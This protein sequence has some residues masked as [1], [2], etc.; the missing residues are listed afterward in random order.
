MAREPRA[1][2]THADILLC[3]ALASAAVVVTL[4]N[5]PLYMQDVDVFM[6]ISRRLLAGQ[7]LYRD[8]WMAYPPGLFYLYAGLMKLFGMSHQVIKLSAVVLFAAVPPMMYLVTRRYASIAA[9]LFAA[10]LTVAVYPPSHKVVI[11]FFS[12]TTLWVISSLGRGATRARLVAA[13]VNVALAMLFKHE[14]GFLLS[15]AVLTCVWLAPAETSLAVRRK[16]ARIAWYVAGILLPVLPT[17][18]YFWFRRALKPF[19][20]DLIVEPFYSVSGMSISI[21]PPLSGG[22]SATIGAWQQEVV[23]H[24]VYLAPVVYAVILL[25]TVGRVLRGRSSGRGFFLFCG[26]LVGCATLVNWIGRTDFPH[27]RQGILPLFV[28][29]AI[30]LDSLLAR[31][32]DRRPA[33]LA[34]RLAGAAAIVGY[35]LWFAA[36]GL[37]G[38]CLLPNAARWE[39]VSSVPPNLQEVVAY[40]DSNVGAEETIFVTPRAMDIYNLT[41]RLNPFKYGDIFPGVFGRYPGKAESELVTNLQAKADVVVFDIYPWTAEPDRNEL[42]EYAPLV[43]SWIEN[44]CRPVARVANRY[45]ILRRVHPPR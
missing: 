1:N 15:L 45:D 40:L 36:A 22:L 20:Y 5:W 34:F 4:Y 8:L 27:V 19:A 35:G 24:V 28:L 33:A 2:I 38:K 12:V 43:N 32:R 30:G 31:L 37:S 18:I 42:S 3:L 14:I 41:G 39:Q 7:V 10:V 11:P 21:K 29:L 9:A 25:G 13:G 6:L 26:A 16:I 44:E 17:V 23:S